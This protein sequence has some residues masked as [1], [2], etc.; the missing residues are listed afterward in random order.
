[1]RLSDEHKSKEVFTL[2]LK[3]TQDEVWFE[4]ST[5]GRDYI[6]IDEENLIKLL[7]G[8]EFTTKVNKPT[9]MLFT[10]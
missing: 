2:V 4:K 3:N 1:M 7:N 6:T 9:N 5:S 10:A 8:E